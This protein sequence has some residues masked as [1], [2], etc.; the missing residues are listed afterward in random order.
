MTNL[1]PCLRLPISKYKPDRFILMPLRALP[2]NSI[3]VSQSVPALFI[4]NCTMKTIQL[5]RPRSIH[6]PLQCQ[7]PEVIL[8]NLQGI[9]GS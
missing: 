4:R 9:S 1:T 8:P 7:R 5:L 2:L 6:I 3:V